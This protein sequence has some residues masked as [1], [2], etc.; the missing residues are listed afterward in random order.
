[1]VPKTYVLCCPV[2][3]LLHANYVTGPCACVESG[4]EDAFDAWAYS[5]NVFIC[6]NV[7][8]NHIWRDSEKCLQLHMYYMRDRFFTF[9]LSSQLYYSFLSEVPNRNS[10][11]HGAVSRFYIHMCKADTD[12]ELDQH[13]TFQHRI[14][15][16]REWLSVLKTLIF[17]LVGTSQPASLCTNDGICRVNEQEQTQ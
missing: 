15:R 12:Y 2:S 4:D 16:D 8:W 3:L 13:G 10:R 1:M 14:Y 6:F 5:P 7:A 11:S 9:F 17:R